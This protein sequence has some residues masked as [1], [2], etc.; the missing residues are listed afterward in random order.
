M[1]SRARPR[2]STAGDDYLYP[3]ELFI[4]LDLPATVVRAIAA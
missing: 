4:A 1:S 3:K 2:A